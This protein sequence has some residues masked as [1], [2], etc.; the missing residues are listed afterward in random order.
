MSG[1]TELPNLDADPDEWD[2]KWTEKTTITVDRW[3]KAHLDHDRNEQP[4]S[5]Y[6]AELR[7]HKTDPLTLTDVDQV[8]KYLETELDSGGINLR[9]LSKKI[10]ADVENAAFRGAKDAIQSELDR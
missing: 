8:I 7:A 4:W 1:E 9:E 6:L 10:S 2:D 5:E 3:V